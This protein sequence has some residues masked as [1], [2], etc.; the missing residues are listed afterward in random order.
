MNQTVFLPP[1]STLNATA[2]PGF[3]EVATIPLLLAGVL[4][5]FG[6]F[7]GVVL[8]WMSPFWRYS[9][10]VIGTLL[11][12]GGLAGSAAILWIVAGG[13]GMDDPSAL[14]QIVM[15]IVAAACLIAPLY[16]TVRLTRRVLSSRA[17]NS[18][19]R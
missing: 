15:W 1:E 7:V 12:P 8:L 10:K 11:L 13:F 6:W 3:V 2:R 5:G 17:A 14:N 16:T 19:N 18:D 4:V 9:D